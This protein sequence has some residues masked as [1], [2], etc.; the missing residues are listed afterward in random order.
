MS[1][2][3][4]SIIL[5]TI[6]IAI[7]YIAGFKSGVKAKYKVIILI[8]GVVIALLGIYGFFVNVINQFL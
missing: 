8:F 3:L 1:I 7:V 5:A 6:G 4:L 2:G